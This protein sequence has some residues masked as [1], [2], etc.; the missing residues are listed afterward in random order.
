MVVAAVVGMGMGINN[1]IDFPRSHAKARQSLENPVLLAWQAAV[2]NDP[3][4]SA[5]YQGH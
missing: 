2:H 4:P 1:Q 3:V 5:Y